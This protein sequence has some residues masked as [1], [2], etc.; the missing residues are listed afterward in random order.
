MIER[1]YASNFWVSI[2]LHF[3]CFLRPV[4]HHLKKEVVHSILFHLIHWTLA[5]KLHSIT[6]IAIMD[7]KYFQNVWNGYKSS[8]HIRFSFFFL[9]CVIYNFVPF[10]IVG[11]IFPTMD[12]SKPP[13]NLQTVHHLEYFPFGPCW[14]C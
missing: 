6:S 9:N 3:S 7:F 1:G 10:L 2:S 4:K 8:A 5:M 11:R 13:S 14:M 12:L